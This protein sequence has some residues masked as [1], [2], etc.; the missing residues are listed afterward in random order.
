MLSKKGIRDSRPRSILFAIIIFMFLLS[1]IEIIIQ[2]SKFLVQVK[3]IHL[4][5][6]PT[7]EDRISQSTRLSDS[8]LFAYFA[9]FQLQVRSLCVRCQCLMAFIQVL[10]GD[11]IVIWRTWAIWADHKHFIILPSMFWL[12]S[13]STSCTVYCQHYDTQVIRR[14]SSYPSG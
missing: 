10:M 13:F 9:L 5:T 3:Y 2:F 7:L 4:G 1:S 11:S 12:I 6:A 8:F 14:N